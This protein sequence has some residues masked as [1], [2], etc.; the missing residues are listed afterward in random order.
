MA[1]QI[2]RDNLGKILAF[3]GFAAVALLAV[4]LFTEAFRLRGMTQYYA[5]VGMQVGWLAA[6]LIVF[7]LILRTYLHFRM[8][9]LLA[10]SVGFLFIAGAYALT[11]IL[12]VLSIQSFEAELAANIAVIIGYGEIAL[13]L[14]FLKT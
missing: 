14:A 3:A 9:K 6:A 2:V 7:Y 13:S 1:L 5:Y 8:H 10:A 12:S 4:N 11:L